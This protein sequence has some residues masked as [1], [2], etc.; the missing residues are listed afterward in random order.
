MKMEMACTNWA[1]CKKTQ[2]EL[3]S[4]A[5]DATDFRTRHRSTGDFSVLSQ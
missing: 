1:T 5:P 3:V 2:H 4:H